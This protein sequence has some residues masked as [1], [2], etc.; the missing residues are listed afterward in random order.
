MSNMKWLETTKEDCHFSIINHGRSIRLGE[1][2]G[3][4]FLGHKLFERDDKENFLEFSL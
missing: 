1:E 2:N 3:N 4:G